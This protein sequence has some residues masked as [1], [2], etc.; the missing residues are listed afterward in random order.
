[1]KQT[2]EAA[3]DVLAKACEKAQKI[4]PGITFNQ[5]A[6]DECCSRFINWRDI[7]LTKFM[8]D[9][10]KELDRHKIA[11][12]LT[13]SI[14]QSN[15]ISYEEQLNDDKVFFGQEVLA[16]QCGLTYMQDQLNR[17]LKEKGL[18]QIERYEMPVPFS[19]KTNYFYVIARNL[20]YEEH[21]TDLEGKKLWALNPLQL[22][23]VY[24]FVELYTLEHL[25][26][27]T[28]LLKEE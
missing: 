10:V 24:Y 20:Y 12:I 15:A 6:Y 7:I 23:N 2:V 4:T 1:M 3:W 5:D 16:V 22:A 8:K 28:E 19:C 17:R 25:G 27:N 14:I 18:Q 21:G 13:V 26:I 11:A 9:D